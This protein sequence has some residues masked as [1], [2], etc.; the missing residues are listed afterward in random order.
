MSLEAL[1]IPV[2]NA[3]KKA[4]MIY[5]DELM[6]C[7]DG[8][9]DAS[10]IDPEDVLNLLIAE[11]VPINLWRDCAVE[12]HRAGRDDVCEEIL[13]TL[14]DSLTTQP[15]GMLITK[16]LNKRLTN[17]LSNPP[18]VREIYLKM[19]SK[20]SPT[21]FYESQI[22]IYNILAAK[23][24]EDYK[25]KAAGGRDQ[26]SN[27]MWI[28]AEAAMKLFFKHIK[29]A[30]D[31]ASKVGTAS[32]DAGGFRRVELTMMLKA[33]Y[34]LASGNCKKAET[35]IKVVHDRVVRMANGGSKQMSI[36]TARRFLFVSL[37]G[38]G[39]CSYLPP[40]SN[41]AVAGEYFSKAVQQ[42]PSCDVSVRVAL[43]SCCFYQEQYDKCQY[44]LDRILAIAPSNSRAL[45]MMAL[46]E[47]VHARKDKANRAQHHRSSYHYSTIAAAIDT[48][49]A[50]AINSRA[51]FIFHCWTSVVNASAD[52]ARPLL[53]STAKITAVN[54][55]TIAL[56]PTFNSSIDLAIGD[57]VRIDK[58]D[59]MF[60]ITNVQHSTD[61]VARVLVL[62]VDQ[63]FAEEALGEQLAQL[64][65]KQLSVVLRL[66]KEALAS[67]ADPLDRA[68]SLFLLGRVYYSLGEIQKAFLY[69]RDSIESSPSMVL[70][71]MYMSQIYLTK[72]DPSS[73][74]ESF[75]KIQTLVRDD[76]DVNAYVILLRGL[77]KGLRCPFEQIREVASGFLFEADLWLTQAQLHQQE[78]SL[79][80]AALRCYLNAL[81][82]LEA[83]GGRSGLSIGGAPAGGNLSLVLSN[84]AVLYQAQGSL[85]LALQYMRRAMA[86]I[87]VSCADA[88]DA[89]SAVKSKFSAVELEDIFYHWGAEF[90]SA[91]FANG[92]FVYSAVS[93][94]AVCSALRAG[95]VLLVDDVIHTV[96]EV[97]AQ[98][99]R[100]TCA[101]LHLYSVQEGD[102]QP[103]YR[104][105]RKVVRSAFFMQQN[106]TLI[107]NYARIL[108]SCGKTTAAVELYLDLVKRHPA[109]IECYLR[110]AKINLDMALYGESA[111]WLS[112]ALDVQGDES[113][114]NI[115]LGDL[116]ALTLNWEDAKRCYEK[117]ITATGGKGSGGKKDNRSMLSL[118][119]MYFMNLH[120][121]LPEKY[122]AHVKDS[123]KFFHH[124][125]S[126]DN[127][128][129]FAAVGLGMVCAEKKELEVAREIF[130]RA[131]EVSGSGGADDVQINLAHIHLLQGRFADAEHLYLATIKALFKHSTNADK[132]L[133]LYETMA[134]AQMKSRRF[135]ESLGS[136]CR[137]VHLDPTSLRCWYNNSIVRGNLAISSMSRAH[138][139]SATIQDNKAQ[140]QIAHALFKHFAGLEIVGKGL[141][142][143][144]NVSQERA[145]VCEKNL[146]VFDEHWSIAVREEAR[147]SGERQRNES[148]HQQRIDLKR[149]EEM[150][151]Q[152]E[153][154]RRR[155]ELQSRAV[156]KSRKLDE[157]TEKWVAS[158]EAAT[159]AKSNRVKGKGKGGGGD[160]D[161]LFADDSSARVPDI[162]LFGDDEEG[163]GAAEVEASSNGYKRPRSALD[164]DDEDLFASDA[165][166]AR[167]AEIDLFGDDDDEEDKAVTAKRARNVIVDDDA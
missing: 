16:L 4:V 136:L 56:D 165:P 148:E 100:T 142:P 138:K 39:I 9:S 144:N 93:D 121:I 82:C 62:T 52:G 92:S 122:E 160:L 108:E 158:A 20:I 132:V 60:N 151:R 162:D 110:V 104:L 97:H 157:L 89:D 91:S 83:A 137:A 109:F 28:D 85:P 37:V 64:E 11:Q 78:P 79:F 80:P 166:L 34:E 63:T 54:A 141:Q 143:D 114:A 153:E 98:G 13:N 21:N 42:C 8:A 150:L 27:P 135:E 123:Y 22:E 128:N 71:W 24:F 55:I 74:L 147:R 75:E 23:S 32:S 7:G 129:L 3:E 38:L 119:N 130:T 87:P 65:I 33:F 18:S 145:N 105:R 149:Q 118:G 99:V 1:I 50:N 15:E 49:F 120:N 90:A 47:Q 84:I 154:Q 45:L 113:D 134:L 68:D 139:S 67:A 12:Y 48:N 58:L 167:A 146:K 25:R 117:V 81:D 127:K 19:H 46:L 51:N 131:R 77:V 140:L 44:A 156:E 164:D 2:K 35:D 106:L 95:D 70:S 17:L 94:L 43:A 103:T 29:L 96:A 53:G 133:A 26:S 57:V 76:K 14:I 72:N 41:Y 115:C 124:V 61:G 163:G 66:V 30:D 102:A 86:T 6:N 125:L 152:Q 111:V 116:Y 161:Y 126:D 155:L 159:Q 101:L 40:K 73:A 69:F 112:R 31:T 5:A 36:E 10:P 88:A 107:Y 59:V